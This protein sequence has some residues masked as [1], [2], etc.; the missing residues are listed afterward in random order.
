MREKLLKMIVLIV[1]STSICVAAKEAKTSVLS[2]NIN[3]LIEEEIARSGTPSLQVAIGYESKVIYENAFGFSD[4]ENKVLASTESKYRTASIA[5][6][7][8]ATSAMVLVEDGL[9]DLDKPIQTYCPQF[10]KKRW[11]ITTRQLLTHTAGIRGY[12]DF[13]ELIKNSSDPVQA[14]LLRYKWVQ[15]QLSQHTRYEGVTQPL[16]LFKDDLLI[17]QPGTDWSYTSFGYRVLACVM[18]GASGKKFQLLIDDSIFKKANM[19]ST[20]ADDAWAIIPNRVSRPYVGLACRVAFCLTNLRLALMCC[21]LEK[22][23]APSDF[24]ITGNYPI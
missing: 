12:L 4:L 5:K 17:F 14:D 11:K 21:R 16:D 10:P 3:T 23:Q 19:G 13:P 24:K 22:P 8:T 9:L 6:W 18:E 1:L 15:E 2:K 20:I 7:F